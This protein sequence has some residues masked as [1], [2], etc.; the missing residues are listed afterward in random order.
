QIANHNSIAVVTTPLTGVS[1]NTTTWFFSHTAGFTSVAQ[2]GKNIDTT[3]AVSMSPA[4]SAK[5]VASISSGSPVTVIFGGDTSDKAMHA[6]QQGGNPAVWKDVIGFPAQA[7]SSALPFTP[8]F[9]GT[10]I[11][12]ADDQGTVYAWPE[13][14]GGS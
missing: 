3:T 2:N 12:A 8:I 13:T 14:N 5:A 10:N 7:A 11:Y 9:D 4:T 6:A 1:V